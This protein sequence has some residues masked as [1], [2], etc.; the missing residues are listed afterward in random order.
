MFWTQLVAGVVGVVVGA[1]LTSLQQWRASTEARRATRSALQME[2]DH[3]IEMD[4]KAGSENQVGWTS[5][6]TDVYRQAFPFLSRLGPDQR[7]KVIDA[8]IAIVD[9]NASAEFLNVW[10]WQQDRAEWTHHLGEVAQ[11]KARTAKL[12][13]SAEG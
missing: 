6:P 5:M 2:F 9:Y 7:R 10:G 11:A 12:V 4:L 3:V 13:L 8:G 1:G